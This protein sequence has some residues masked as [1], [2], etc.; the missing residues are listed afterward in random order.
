MTAKASAGLNVLQE[1]MSK[2][3]SPDSSAKCAVMLDV[4]MSC[5]R[6]YPIRWPVPKR[7]TLG[8]PYAVISMRFTS[9]FVNPLIVVDER[10]A[11]GLHEAAFTI[12]WYPQYDL[13]A[14]RFLV[15][16][17]IYLVVEKA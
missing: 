12:R 5:I 1:N 7:T 6:L 14:L 16:L 11:P 2:Y 10:I 9:S 4:S 17:A 15:A 3:A 8:G 13:G